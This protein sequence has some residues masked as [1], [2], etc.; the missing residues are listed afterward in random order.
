[1]GG[2]WKLAAM[3]AVIGAGL[4]VAWQAQ[5]GVKLT[6]SQPGTTDVKEPDPSAFPAAPP[7]FVDQSTIDSTG[8]LLALDTASTPS[9]RKRIESVAASVPAEP[10]SDDPFAG[11]SLPL[12]ELQTPPAGERYQRGLDFKQSRDETTTDAADINSFAESD[13]PF[14]RTAADTSAQS[15]ARRPRPGEE[16]PIRTADSSATEN[17]SQLDVMPA[18]AQAPD[19]AAADPFADS[20]PPDFPSMPDDEA[21]K[22]ARPPVPVAEPAPAEEFDPFADAPT[23]RPE[24]ATSDSTIDLGTPAEPLPKRLP[25]DL[26]APAESI[27]SPDRE[28]SQLDSRSN[29]SRPSQPARF[30]AEP[31]ATEDAS[32]VPAPS[33]FRTDDSNPAPPPTST[34]DPLLGD[35][36]VSPT[37]PRGVQEPRLTIQKVAPQKAVLGQPLIYTVIVKNIGGSPATQVVVEDRIPKGARLVGTSPRAELTDKRLVWKLDT[38]APNDERKI[39]IKVIPEEEGPLGSVAKVNFVSEV[40][41]EIVITAPELKLRVSAPASANMGEKVEMIFTIMNTGEGDAANV[42][43]RSVLP[44]GLQHPAGKD[45]EYTVGKLPAQQSRDVSLELT[46]TKPGRVTHRATVTADGN[47]GAD[48][49]TPLE[50]HG[51][52]LVLTR[53]G[54]SKVY[55]GRAAQFANKIANEGERAV[56]RVNVSEVIPTGF[57]FVEASDGGRFDPATR[58]I[59]WAVGPVAPRAEQT[60]TATLLPKAVGQFAGTITSTGPTGSVATVKQTIAVEGFPSLAIESTGDERLVAVG[61]QL[62]SQIQLR[63]RGSAAAENVGLTIVIP[64]ELRVVSA[65]GPSEYQLVGQKLVFDPVRELGPRDSAPFDVVVEALSAGDARLEL[66]ITADHLKRPIKHE[67]AVQ[68]V[69]DG[70]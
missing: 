62:T 68:V 35:G 67:E 59:T 40:A 14:S 33:R 53:Q 47:A 12:P 46:A 16:V 20:A 69:G 18:A 58:T 55:V 49:A 26:D 21:P 1:M 32:A 6:S 37:S 28:P 39:A 60:I 52:E 19:D 5:Q 64:A 2:L 50:I 9:P 15:A 3:S 24:A 36:Q 29:E 42:V 11:P 51:E 48:A 8:D 7:L 63:N 45:L 57:E 56:H 23:A 27:A 17:E 4:V 44:E 38:L 54:P 22:R 70:Q 10:S 65:K 41:A 61:E 34:D 13:D 30:T 43:L 31:A 66:Q 25:I